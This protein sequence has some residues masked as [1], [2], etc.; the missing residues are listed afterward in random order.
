MPASTIAALPEPIRRKLETKL[1][2][3]EKP[4]A[5]VE[6]LK[7]EGYSINYH[8]VTRYGSKIRAKVQQAETVA[9][10]LY[11]TQRIEEA[12]GIELKFDLLTEAKKVLLLGIQSFN[13]EEFAVMKPGELFGAIA[14]ICAIDIQLQKFRQEMR[15]KVA[16]EIKKHEGQPG[17]DEQT[18][19]TIRE[20]VYGIFDASD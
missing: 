5:V 2:S 17:I 13:I 6:W 3:G 12:T 16:L 15:D 7:N 20:S 1:R 4:I 14:R 19:V 18:L 9:E 8:A 11:A 10:T